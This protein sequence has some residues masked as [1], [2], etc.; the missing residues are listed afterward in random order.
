MALRFRLLALLSAALLLASCA[1]NPVRETTTRVEYG[2]VE[3]VEVF[4]GSDDKPVNAGTVVGGIAG[5]VLGHQIGS[6]SGQ[7]AA[8]IVGAIGGAVVGHEIDRKAHATRYRISV[9]LD[10]GSTLVVEDTH[11]VDLRAG[12]RVRVENDRIRR[13]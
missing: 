3:S 11:D 5:G 13:I 9:R 8:T 6:G 7:T 10:S 12:D 4:R 2:Y 1:D